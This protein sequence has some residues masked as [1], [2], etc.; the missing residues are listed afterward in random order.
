MRLR[1]VHRSGT[2]P[3]I[4]NLD[5]P[6]ART[7][8][9]KMY[10]PGQ[11]Q[12][13]FL[14]TWRNQSSPHRNIAPKMCSHLVVTKRAQEDND[15][16]ADVQGKPGDASVLRTTTFDE[17][18]MGHEARIHEGGVVQVSPESHAGE[19]TAQPTKK[20]FHGNCEEHGGER[21]QP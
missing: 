14:I 7:L 20:M 17:W 21:G 2:K 6:S 12:Y 11:D 19:I 5:P 15:R 8:L 3:P 4:P 9:P 18:Q 10:V 16:F 1:K 13:N